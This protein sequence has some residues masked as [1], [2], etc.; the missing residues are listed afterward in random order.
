ML[1]L[2]FLTEIQILFYS[3]NKTMQGMFG[4]ESAGK[5]TPS[6]KRKG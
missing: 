2:N 5:P 3:F 4:L 6:T 1:Y